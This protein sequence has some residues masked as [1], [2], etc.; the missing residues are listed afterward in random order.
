M[1]TVCCAVRCL[2]KFG[3]YPNRTHGADGKLRFHDANPVRLLNGDR[4][5]TK[6]YYFTFEDVTIG[7]P[8]V[9][10]CLTP[11]QIEELMVA[12]C[13]FCSD[14]LDV[15]ALS[16]L[17]SCIPKTTCWEHSICPM[18]ALCTDVEILAVVKV[19]GSGVLTPCSGLS[20]L[21][22]LWPHLLEPEPVAV[23]YRRSVE[24][25]SSLIR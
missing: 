21:L 10:H 11:V 23:S 12:I 2:A 18:A 8:K 15:I 19:R 6:F 4:V 5:H 20:P 1:H 25:S 24:P 17:R 16:S 22:R 7:N 14:R 3:I 13:A 9:R